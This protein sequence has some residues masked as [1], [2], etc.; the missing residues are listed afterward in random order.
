M[1]RVEVVKDD[2]MA[3]R[4]KIFDGGG[5]NGVAKAAW[6]LMAEDDEDVHGSL[7]H[8]AIHKAITGIVMLSDPRSI[9]SER[10]AKQRV[11]NAEAHAPNPIIATAHLIS[12]L[13]PPEAG[14]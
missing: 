11:C 2:L 12:Q 14:R 3:G 13:R 1:L 9:H 7:W 8:R 4:L 6:A 5:G 10:V